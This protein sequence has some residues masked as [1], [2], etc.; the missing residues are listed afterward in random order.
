[1]VTTMQRLL[2]DEIVLEEWQVR[3]NC[4]FRE[5][6]SDGEF[7]PSHRCH[8]Q[9][10]LNGQIGVRDV[11]I[12]TTCEPGDLPEVCPMLA[13]DFKIRLAG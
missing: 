2:T 1:M 11:P 6:M 5:K 12:T 7:G 4:L 8:L 3:E 10:Y 9:D 13:G